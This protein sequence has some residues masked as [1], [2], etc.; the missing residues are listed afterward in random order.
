MSLNWTCNSQGSNSKGDGPDDI[1]QALVLKCKQIIEM[2]EG[3]HVTPTELPKISHELDKILAY[4]GPSC[5]KSASAVEGCHHINASHFKAI[6]HI[7]PLKVKKSIRSWIFEHSVPNGQAF[8]AFCAHPE[9]YTMEVFIRDCTLQGRDPRSIA[10]S[11][12]ERA[13]ILFNLGF[14]HVQI[15]LGSNM[16]WICNSQG[17]N[18]KGDGP[19][20]TKKGSKKQ[21]SQTK[22]KAKKEQRRKNADAA[23]KP[24]AFGVVK[25]IRSDVMQE[26]LYR[27]VDGTLFSDGFELQKWTGDVV[28]TT[29]PISVNTLSALSIMSGRTDGPVSSIPSSY[30]HVHWH[31]LSVTVKPC[32]Q[33]T[34]NG[35]CIMGWIPADSGEIPSQASIHEWLAIRRSA[36][37]SSSTKAR[38]YTIWKAENMKQLTFQGLLPGGSKKVNEIVGYIFY[39]QLE[40]V[41]IPQEQLVN[42]TTAATQSAAVPLIPFKGTLAELYLKVGLTAQYRT[43][44][45]PRGSN[46]LYTPQDTVFTYPL[47]TLSSYD[48]TG[49]DAYMWPMVGL[50]TRQ[51]MD[52]VTNTENSNAQNTIS[53]TSSTAGWILMPTTKDANAQDVTGA[54]PEIFIWVTDSV[55]EAFGLP[56]KVATMAMAGVDIFLS[57]AASVMS[58]FEQKTNAVQDANNQEPDGTCGFGLSTYAGIATSNAYQPHITTGNLALTPACQKLMADLTASSV[59]AY[60]LMGA[61]MKQ[62]TSLAAN[63]FPLLFTWPTDEPQDTPVLEAIYFE[64]ADSPSTLREYPDPSRLRTSASIT[65]PPATELDFFPSRLA[66]RKPMSS[67]HVPLPAQVVSRMKCQ[68]CFYVQPETLVPSSRL[69]AVGFLSSTAGSLNMVCRHNFDGTGNH[70]DVMDEISSLLGGDGWSYTDSYGWFTIVK[71]PWR[72]VGSLTGDLVIGEFP[73]N[74]TAAPTSFIPI[75]GFTTFRINVIGSGGGGADVYIEPVAEHLVRRVNNE[76]IGDHLLPYFR[77]NETEAGSTDGYVFA[78]GTDF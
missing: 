54:I 31:N 8:K 67:L 63:F 2:I 47:V 43:Y 6:H 5:E 34:L 52:A 26:V 39:G 37:A 18:S 13:S 23:R 19:K 74:I 38:D 65:A 33:S 75:Q 76:S 24:A 32:A 1:A 7:A 10:V 36:A 72:Y 46:A 20:G 62:W 3:A 30:T 50:G 17:A 69:A 22:G 15:S 27:G 55:L 25:E 73:I 35:L 53:Y 16:S 14:D 58:E 70:P 42:A 78:C 56:P 29:I 41:L 12:N 28:F 71:I 59:P 68:P 51:F 9:L 66:P 40:P 61:V 77:F 49:Q 21:S 45:P 60:Q 57:L 48:T 11:V 44:V 4:A 64:T